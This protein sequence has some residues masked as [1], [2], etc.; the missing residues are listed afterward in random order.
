MPFNS[1]C[2]HGIAHTERRSGRRRARRIGVKSEARATAVMMVMV[3]MMMMMMT[4]NNST[5]T[6]FHRASE[7]LRQS[8]F[9]HQ[10]QQTAEAAPP[11]LEASGAALER[12]DNS[13][14][15]D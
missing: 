14:C 10:T 6:R 4:L 13:C 3:V 2:F 7:C 9:G 15:S 11:P 12:G 8:N 1:N 5:I